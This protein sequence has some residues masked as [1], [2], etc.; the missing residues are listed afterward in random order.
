MDDNPI[1]YTPKELLEHY[2]RYRGIPEDDIAAIARE[3]WDTLPNGELWPLWEMW[4]EMNDQGYLP[5]PLTGMGPPR[6][7]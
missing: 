1:D 6:S 7:D 3:L 2:C 5:R 4:E